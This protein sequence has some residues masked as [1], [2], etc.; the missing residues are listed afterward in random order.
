MVYGILGAS[1]LGGYLTFIRPLIYGP[2][3]KK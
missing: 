2:S 3:L 1:V